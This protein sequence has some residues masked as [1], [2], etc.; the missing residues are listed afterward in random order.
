PISKI[1]DQMN[2]AY[3]Y[4]ANRIWIVNVG[5][6]KPMEF[7]ID[8]FLNYAWDPSRWPAERLAEFTQLWGERE[9]GR[10]HAG[11]IAELITGYTRFNGRRKPELLEPGTYSLAS[12]RE[13]ETVQADYQRLAEHAE[14][15]YEAMPAEKKDAFFELVLYPI[16]ACSIVNEMYIAAGKNR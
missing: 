5:D 13:A 3:R 15:L 14:R 12:Y 4:G 11:E 6:L 16:K 9:F 10:D 1:W 7:P 2:L 8:F